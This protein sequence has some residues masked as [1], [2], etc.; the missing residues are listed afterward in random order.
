V[1]REVSELEVRM[2][3][4]LPIGGA[5]GVLSGLVLAAGL[6]VYARRSQRRIS[7]D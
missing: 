3:P 4:E 1:P 7:R 6:L 5:A 2:D